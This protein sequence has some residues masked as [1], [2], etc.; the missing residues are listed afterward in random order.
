MSNT[1]GRFRWSV[2]ALIALATV[3]NYLDRNALAVMWPEV[4]KEIGATKEDYALLVTIFMIF[5]AFGQLAVERDIAV[6]D[7]SGKMQRQVIAMPAAA[8]SVEDI[9]RKG[10]REAVDFDQQ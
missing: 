7:L 10:I 9:E 6:D 3:I 4:S 5:Y 8:S 1:K 2:I